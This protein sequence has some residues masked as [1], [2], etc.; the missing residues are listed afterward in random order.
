M[1]PISG[2]LSHGFLN[3]FCFSSASPSAPLHVLSAHDHKFNF[4]LFGFCGVYLDFLLKISS[5]R[6]STENVLHSSF[7]VQI[8]IKIYRNE[9][10]TIF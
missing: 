9:I 6:N 7:A 10:K 4:G 2:C 8:E 5:S 1:L 3:T